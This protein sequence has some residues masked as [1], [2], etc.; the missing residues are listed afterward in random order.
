MK[1]HFHKM[2]GAGYDFILI[3]GTGLRADLDWP[4]IAVSAC[5]RRTG[6][7]ADGLIVIR[8]HPA[9]DATM[10]YFNADGSTDLCF[11]PGLGPDAWVLTE[12]SLNHQ[13]GGNLIICGLSAIPLCQQ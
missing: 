12:D 13:R 9:Y 4:K 11:D 3:D 6:I 7:G 5:K 2:S 10:L 1:I 8:D